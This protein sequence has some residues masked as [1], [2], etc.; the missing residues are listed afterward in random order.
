MTLMMTLMMMIWKWN[1]CSE[2]TTTLFRRRRVL[3]TVFI[4]L[5]KN[6]YRMVMPH[7]H[8]HWNGILYSWGSMNT[9]WS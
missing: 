1:S 4:I 6:E 8:A 2:T 9:G 7:T 5:G 3:V